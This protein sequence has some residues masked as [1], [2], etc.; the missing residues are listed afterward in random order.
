MVV[1]QQKPF[2]P[3]SCASICASCVPSLNPLHPIMKIY[4]S[5]FSP[6]L[7]IQLPFTRSF[8]IC[9]VPHFLTALPGSTFSRF[10]E[11]FP[12]V[13]DWY[14]R[15]SQA[16]YSSLVLME[17]AFSTFTRADPL[18]KSS[19]ALFLWRNCTNPWDMLCKS[20]LQLF[21]HIGSSAI[22]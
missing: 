2:K 22:T 10:S 3:L 6:Q 19:G 12:W 21:Y 11:T 1:L 18:T 4:F 7:F 5:I 15:E 14:I 17:I 8:P 16:F 9:Q 13:S 20:W